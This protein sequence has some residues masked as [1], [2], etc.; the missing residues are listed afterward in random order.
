[1]N[2]NVRRPQNPDLAERIEQVRE[3][4]REINQ[5][6]FDFAKDKRG[7]KRI[8][9]LGLAALGILMYK[10]SDRDKIGNLKKAYHTDTFSLLTTMTLFL[11]NNVE[12]FDDFIE[13]GVDDSYSNEGFWTSEDSDESP[14]SLRWYVDEETKEKKVQSI[15]RRGALRLYGPDTELPPLFLQ[16]SYAPTVIIWDIERCEVEVSKMRTLEDGTLAETSP[17]ID[18]LDIKMEILDT[19]HTLEWQT[20]TA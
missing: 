3:S 8:T 4:S 17:V 11:E 5:I 14:I 10:S 9:S 18:E 7:L 2:F 15:F 12:G 19:L 1:M 13:N 16:R 20:I 6:N